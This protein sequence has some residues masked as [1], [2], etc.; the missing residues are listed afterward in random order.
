MINNIKVE[1]DLYYQTGITAK[2]HQIDVYW[3]FKEAGIKYKTIVQAKD[4]SS[5]VNLEKLL[6][7]K[8]ILNDIPGQ[9]RG[10]IVTRSGYQSGPRDFAE[11][12]GIILYELREPTAKDMADRI[13]IFNIKIDMFTPHFENI[14]LKQDEEWNISELKKKNISLSEAFLIKIGVS[15]STRLYD[16]DGVVITTMQLLLNSLVPKEMVELQP[17]NKT[18]TFDK[19]TFI[20]T[21]D[22]R[23]P[24]MKIKAIDVSIFKTLTTMEYKLEDQDFVGYILKNVIDGEKEQGI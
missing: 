13:K 14:H 9:P 16:E 23:V 22:A 21:E 20:E 5:P 12:N 8:A 24:R 11:K 6:V 7:F 2:H 19:P 4:W 1:H 17:T 15:D 3:E 10:V 18:Y